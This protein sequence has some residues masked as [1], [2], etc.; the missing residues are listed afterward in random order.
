LNYCHFQKPIG[1]QLSFIVKYYPKLLWNKVKSSC[2]PEYFSQEWEDTLYL[3][4][5]QFNTI[6][7]LLDMEYSILLNEVIDAN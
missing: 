4:H 5:Y 1:A 6:S 3:W 2:L 7:Y